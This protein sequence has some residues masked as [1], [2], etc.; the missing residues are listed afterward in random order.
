MPKRHEKELR[1]FV[2]RARTI[3]EQ[4]H[5]DWGSAAQRGGFQEVVNRE[6]PKHS[7]DPELLSV[8]NALGGVIDAIESYLRRAG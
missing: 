7:P 1:D 6:M 2:E 3:A 5:Q 4:I 8:E